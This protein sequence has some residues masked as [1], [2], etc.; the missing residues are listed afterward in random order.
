MLR[1]HKGKQGLWPANPFCL[2]GFKLGAIG[3]ELGGACS[4]DEPIGLIWFYIG[5]RREPGLEFAGARGL[6]SQPGETSL[7]IPSESAFEAESRRV[8]EV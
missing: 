6:N 1:K 2:Q 8:S 3:G 7:R 4:N 5:A